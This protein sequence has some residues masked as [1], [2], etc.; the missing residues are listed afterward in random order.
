MSS[1]PDSA[2]SS[3]PAAKPKKQVSTQRRVISWVFIAILL[4][5]VL[6]EWRAK[7]SQAKTFENLGAAM[8]A[9]AGG[10]IPFAQFE[11]SIQGSPSVEIDE[12]GLI[13]RLYHYKWNGIFKTYHMRLLVNDEDLVVTY[14]ALPEGDTVNKM[15]R[16]SK[17]SMQDLVEKNKQELADQNADQKPTTEKPTETPATPEP[18]KTETPEKETAAPKN[19]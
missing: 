5:V 2:D 8:E 18:A 16:I 11:E 15:R 12:S 1:T 10:E 19:E 13:M 7:S 6:L 3:K 17:K 14:D 9:E 4:G